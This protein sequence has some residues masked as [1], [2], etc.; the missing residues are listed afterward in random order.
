MKKIINDPHTVVP[1]MLEG[2]VKSRND[3]FY[4]KDVEVV[5]RKGK[6]ANKVGL[7]SGGGAGHEPAHGGYVG[8]GLLD[9]AVSGNVFASPSPDQILEGIQ[10]ANHGA[11]V[12]LIVKNYSGDIMNFE[13]AQEMAQMEGIPVAMVVIRDDVAVEESTHSTGRRG[14][15]GTVLVHKIAGAKAES[16]GSLEEVTAVVEKAI[17]FVR[18][19]GCSLSSCTIPA[20]GKPGFNIPEGHMELGMGIHGESGVLREPV[21]SALELSE[22]M[23]QAILEDLPMEGERVALLINGLGATPLMELYILAKEVY[24]TLA[25]K[26]ISV[27]ISFVGNYMTSLEMAGCSISLMKLDDE[28]I[29]LLRA[30]CSSAGLTLMEENHEM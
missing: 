17:K 3:L 9:A 24:N 1:E 22:R 18:S 15:A 12:L 23:V 7:V 26:N 14:I 25:R 8:F 16:G 21:C 28:L 20:V 5:Y 2:L 10:R 29:S 30:P 6:S 11:G 4:V 13:M 27:W 19:F